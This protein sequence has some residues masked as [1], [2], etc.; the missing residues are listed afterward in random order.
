MSSIDAISVCCRGRGRRNDH[1]NAKHNDYN[2]NIIDI[3]YNYNYDN[4]KA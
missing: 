4:T 2:Y 3:H 1:Y